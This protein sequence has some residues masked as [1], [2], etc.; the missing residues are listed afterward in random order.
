MKQAL[1]SVIGG[2]VVAGVMVNATG[3]GAALSV[4]AGG[5]CGIVLRQSAVAASASPSGASHRA[6][7]DR[8]CV[9]CHNARLKTAGLTLDTMDLSEIAS[10][11][12]VWEKVVRKLRSGSMPPASLPRPDPAVNAALVTWLEARLD[13]A[14]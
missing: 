2:V 14:G 1:I 6:L 11:A 10:Q 8:Y 5:A 7:L 12:E 4:K 13:Q 9:T 3:H